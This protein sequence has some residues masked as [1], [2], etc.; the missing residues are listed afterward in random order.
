M[1]LRFRKNSLRLRVNQREAEAL[2]EGSV[3]EEQI[4]FPGSATLSYVLRPIPGSDGAAS[5]R[6]GVILIGAPR[7]QLQAWAKTDSIGIYFDLP[8]N[9]SPLRVAIEKDLECLDGPEE[10][11]D[12]NAYPRTVATSC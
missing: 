4:Q 9:G 1:K 6:N 11:R 2:A 10:E 8:V 7:E 12:P 3:L 5:F